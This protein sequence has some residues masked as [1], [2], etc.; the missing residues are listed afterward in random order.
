[1]ST[2][3]PNTLGYSAS[4]DKVWGATPNTQADTNYQD[5]ASYYGRV[6]D[7][8]LQEQ[9]RTTSPGKTVQRK[10]RKPKVNVQDG[11]L[12]GASPSKTVSPTKKSGKQGSLKRPASG[13][14]KA[15]PNTA[16]RSGR[17]EP[18]NVRMGVPAFGTQKIANVPYEDSPTKNKRLQMAQST[19]KDLQD[20]KE[21]PSPTKTGIAIG[22]G[23]GKA[24]N[25]FYNPA[26]LEKV[27]D[28]QEEFNRLLEERNT[29]SPNKR[30]GFGA[31]SPTRA[32][33][34]V[35][36]DITGKMVVP[37]GS[38][39]AGGDEFYKVLDQIYGGNMKKHKSP[40]KRLM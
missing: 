20:G 35:G 10:A 2:K 39:L 17:P 33:G 5:E 25:M 4:P 22:S 11:S 31:S 37:E 19:R 27:N 13:T 8:S 26:L 24:A 18:V 16:A 21:V 38:S 3:K 9:A 34:S 7:L 29:R 12:L 36:V 40:T 15:R 14:K 32:K 30:G 6:P 28:I 23:G 1:M